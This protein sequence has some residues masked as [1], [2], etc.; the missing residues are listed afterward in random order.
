MTLLPKS[1]NALGSDRQSWLWRC[2]VDLLLFLAIGVLMLIGLATIYS[3]SGQSLEVMDRQALR[4]LLAIS[5]MLVVAQIPP[6]LIKSIGFWL[7]IV[8]LI[9]LLCVLQFGDISKG[10][11]RWIRIFGV[12]FQPSEIMKIA[13]P[14]M[15]AGYL[16]QSKLPPSLPRI[17]VA[18]LLTLVPAVLIAKQPDLGTAIMIATSGLGVIFFAGISW[19]LILT[20][21]TLIGSF[22]PVLWYF[23]MHDYQR[24]RVL[25]LFDPE[26]DPLGSGYHIIQSKIAIGSGGLF[27]KGWLNGTQSRLD[28]L[29]E[30]TTDFIFAVFSEEFGLVGIGCLL[31]AYLALISRGLYIGSQAQD[32][33]S[34][35]V[36]G[37]ITLTLFVYMFVNMGMVSGMMP[38][39]GVPLLLISYGGTALVTMMLGFGL[40]MSI[41]THKTRMTYSG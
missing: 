23:L 29:P 32:S 8:G 27:G 22:V 28:F 40:L 21:L 39:V 26:R 17:L 1:V 33:F 16:S 19:W 4:F 15:V 9:L 20:M 41:H 24:Q 34:R 25:T 36:S 6:R 37:S 35:M 7:F 2:H 30:R 3:A 11:Q 5:C 31:L 14:L 18:L 38:V 10:A 12:R 13:V